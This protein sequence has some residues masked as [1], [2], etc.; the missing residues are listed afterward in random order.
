MHLLFTWWSFYVCLTYDIICGIE[1]FFRV[2]KLKKPKYRTTAKDAGYSWV[3]ATLV[4][5]RV[6][7]RWASESAEPWWLAVKGAQ[8][9]RVD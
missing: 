6:K 9:D 8:W 1:T 5:D 4:S 7:E 2:Y 3:L